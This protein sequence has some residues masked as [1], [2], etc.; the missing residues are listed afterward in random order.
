M[1]YDGCSRMTCASTAKPRSWNISSQNDMEHRSSP[2]T[3]R[4]AAASPRAADESKSTP[5][6]DDVD[7]ARM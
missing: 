2:M 6:S 4:T 7:A 1:A 3:S 5:E